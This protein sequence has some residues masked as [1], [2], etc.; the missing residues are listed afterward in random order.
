MD[1]G[2]LLLPL[3]LQQNGGPPPLLQQLLL[4]HGARVTLVLGPLLL[5]DH[6]TPAA[7]PSPAAPPGRCRGACRAAPRACRADPRTSCPW[8]AACPCLGAGEAPHPLRAHGF[9]IV[10]FAEENPGL[11]HV[12][13]Q[14]VD[15]LWA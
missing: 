2:H 7:G 12:S 5:L 14:P 13:L 6:H 10:G 11:D 1:L 9:I 8:P 3:V 15:P 4:L